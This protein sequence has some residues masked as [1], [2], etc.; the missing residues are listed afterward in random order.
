MQDDRIISY[1][2]RQ[3]RKHEVNYPTHDLEMAAVVFALRIWQSY[4]YGEKIL[5]FTDHK[6][7]KYLFTQPDLNLRQRRWMEFVADY[8]MHILYHP[9]KENVVADALSRRKVD[10]DIEK[11]LQNLETEFKMIKCQIRDVN[12]KKIREQLIE[13]NFGGYQVAS[14]GTLLLNGSVTVPK[15][16]G[17]REEIL[18]TAHHS[19]LSI[20][21]GSTKMYRDIRRYYHWP[22]MKRDVA[23]WVSQCQTCQQIKAEHQVPSGLLQSLPIPE[24]KWD[25][26]AMDFISGLPGAPGRGNDAIW[27]IDRLTKSAHFLLMKL[28]DK[29][30]T[31][32]ELYLK[33]IVKLHGVTANIVSDRDPRFTAKFWRPFQQA[34]GTDLHMSTVFHPETD[35][36][37]E[38]TIRTLED[39]LR[40]CI[41][42]WN[43]PWD[44]FLPLIEFS[45]NNSYHSSIGMSPYEALYGRPCRTPVCWAEVGE[46]RMFGPEIV[47]EAAEKVRVI[48]ANMKKAQDRQK[49]YADRGRRE[50]SFAVNDL[51]F[52]KV[53]A[54]KGNERF[55]KVGKLATRYIGPYRI[56]TKVGEVAYRLELPPDMPM[57]PVFHVS[58]TVDKKVDQLDGRLTPL[59]ELEVIYDV[60]LTEPVADLAHEKLEESDSEE[61]LDETN[62]TIGY[63]EL[64]GSSIGFNSARDTLSFSNGPITR[65]K[66]RQLK[67]TILRLVYTKPISTSEENQVKE[68]LKIFNCSIFNIT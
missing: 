6:S 34:L 50:V 3:L 14:D 64:D 33:E 20:H 43:G 62:T 38:R 21:P 1:A 66:T 8:D 60:S 27:V 32:A 54:H 57:H 39:L 25:A 68:T 51:V 36:Q 13:G 67:E 37:T 65:S 9:G 16:E 35:G 18:R 15:S 41:L 28:T 12:L 56:V 59:E 44:K 22:G 31:L 42:D 46:R 19:L 47:D 45:Y 49:K 17:L 11:E 29:V 55:G 23:T 52:L 40:L 7:L 63:K 48:Q 5:V 53:A 2:S 24:W 10:V 4:L 61:E 58:M 26:V 30:E